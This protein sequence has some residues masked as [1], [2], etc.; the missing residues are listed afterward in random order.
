MKGQASCAYTA[1]KSCGFSPLHLFY[2]TNQV[3][4]YNNG[5]YAR[6]PIGTALQY[7]G[8]LEVVELQE[9]RAQK[10]VQWDKSFDR[11]SLQK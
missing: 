3:N 4:F 10:I 5:E 1:Y 6:P 7:N 8:M 11:L 9:M 2:L